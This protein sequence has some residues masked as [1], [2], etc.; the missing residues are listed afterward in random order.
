MFYP[1]GVG[2]SSPE[3]CPTAGML[4]GSLAHLHKA[5][6]GAKFIGHKRSKPE[7][8]LLPMQT[9]P[10]LTSHL[11]SMFSEDQNIF[12]YNFSFTYL[13]SVCWGGAYGTERV[14]R[15]EVNMQELVPLLSLCG[16]LGFNLMGTILQALILLSWWTFQRKSIVTHSGT[17]F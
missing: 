5:L 11:S 9:H 16:S 13:L 12:S 10:E 1:L 3:C 6:G 14:W 7:L 8:A 4:A 2:V 17:R 15:S